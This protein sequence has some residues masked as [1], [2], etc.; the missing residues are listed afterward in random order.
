MFRRRWCV[1]QAE[2]APALL[3]GSIIT[4]LAAWRAGVYPWKLVIAFMAAMLVGQLVQFLPTPA[5]F[6]RNLVSGLAA[7]TIR[8]IGF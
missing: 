7:A 1:F 5:W 8:W 4:G 6:G 2:A 3:I